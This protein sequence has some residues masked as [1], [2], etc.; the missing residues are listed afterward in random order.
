MATQVRMTK[1]P[2]DRIRLL[3]ALRLVGNLGLQPAVELADYLA[4]VPNS[5]VAAGLEPGIAVHIASELRKA[6][7]EVAVEDS[8]V[9]TPMLCCP[10]ANEKFEWSFLR[11]IKKAV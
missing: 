11:R 9:D 5:V 3:R 6:G 10:S 4:K 7:A 2:G 8:S 1:L